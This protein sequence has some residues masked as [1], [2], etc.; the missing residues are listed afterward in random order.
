MAAR[1]NCPANSPTADK[2]KNAIAVQQWRERKK[3]EEKKIENGIEHYKADN[4]RLRN[5]MNE[6]EAQMSL[7]R[8][9]FDGVG[10]GVG[11]GGGD[12]GGGCG[13][14]VGVEGGDGGEEF[15]R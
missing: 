10:G 14:G 13:G 7:L 6:M 9:I 2:S 3:E 4:Q 5:S 1:H 12:G 11:C 15:Y 8:E